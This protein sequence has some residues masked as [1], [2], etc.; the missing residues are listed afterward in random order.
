MPSSAF[1]AV[2]HDALGK[3]VVAGAFEAAQLVVK[4]DLVEE[5]VIDP[6][7]GRLLVVEP[8]KAP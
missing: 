7:Q 5:S 2:K 1:P 8:A 3:E 4:Y 6:W